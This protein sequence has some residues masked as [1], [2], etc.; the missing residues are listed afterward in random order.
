MSWA[1]GTENGRAVGYAITAQCDA[2][3]TMIDRGVTFRCGGAS[4]ATTG[5]PGCGGFFCAQHRD[6]RDLCAA[7]QATTPDDEDE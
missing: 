6:W 1:R 3:P 5:E 2:C 7:C 4:N